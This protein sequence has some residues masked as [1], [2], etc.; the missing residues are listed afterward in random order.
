MRLH[1]IS[2]QVC[3][4]KDILILIGLFLVAFSIRVVGISNITLYGDEW[5]YWTE[6]NRILA[7]NFAPRADVF[8][9]APPFLS[10]IGAIVTFLF[11]ADLDV[12]RMVSVVFGS[13]TVPFLYLFGSAMYDRKTG[14]LSAFLLSFSAYHSLYSRIFM[15]EA[16]TLFFI[17]AFLYFFWISQ[18]SEQRKGILYA[19]FAG[20]MMGMAFDAK[21]ISF[22]LIPSVLIY[23]LWIERFSFK[24]LVD[25]RMMVMAMFALLFYSPILICLYTT[26]VGLHPFYF[27]VIDKFSKSGV[28]GHTRVV[29]LPLSELLIEGGGKALEVLSTWGADA[30]LMPWK[31]L[32]KF[33]AAL[34]F[35]LL[36]CY[37]LYRFINSD[38]TD[39]FLIIAFFTVFIVL[40]GIGNQRHYVVYA[41]PFYYVMLSHFSIQIFSQLKK[42]NNYKNIFRI[43]IILIIGITFFS[44][45]IAGV[46]SS[47]WDVGDSYSWTAGTVEYIKGDIKKNSY[48]R[49]ILIGIFDY[50]T[51][52]VEY[53]FFSSDFDIC[54]IPMLT[55]ES[56]HS[57]ELA[58]VDL[59]RLDKFKPDYLVLNEAFYKQYFKGN[60]KTKIFKDYSIVFHLPAYPNK[61]FV[62]KRKKIQPR[63]LLLQTNVKKGEIAQD[64]FNRSV[65]VTMEVG[66]AYSVLVQVKNTADS[67]TNFTIRVNSSKFI[68][69]VDDEWR[70]VA[71]D[72]GSTCTFKFII[73]PF[74]EH[75]EELPITVDL[76][77]THEKVDSVSDYIRSIKKAPYG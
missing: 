25:R 15:L 40:L 73:V 28:V 33:S 55:L 74:K 76:Y 54:T 41:Q 20:A 12:L 66:K 49:P 34:L 16:L 3:C 23:V 51:E 17:T 38:K 39:S 11:G 1:F 35:I 30:L 70:S 65:P 60:V 6:T 52:M 69:F 53:L 4:K 46:T 64:I 26:G 24:A 14:L 5:G 8:D 21:Y 71:L 72:K 58:E 63:E 47:H 44:S 9:Y 68:I 67:R 32:F 42:E 59:D 36:I 19:A 56:G 57:K 62:F 61:G 22:F 45:F 10:Y 75:K 31:Y 29:S 37:Y 18:H 50:R 7:N 27:M 48:E 77:A 13:L 2:Q 43:F